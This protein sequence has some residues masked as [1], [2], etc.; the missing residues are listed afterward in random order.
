MPSHKHT[1]TTSSDGAHT[2]TIGT[3]MDTAYNSSGKCCSVHKDGIDPS[4]WNGS[5]SSA[6]AHTHT[7]T[8]K[9]TGG[10]EAHNNMPPYL[11]VYIWKRVE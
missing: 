8:V 11:V 5:T 9:T 6:G 4:Y 10:G 2:H 1:A 3:D 7:I